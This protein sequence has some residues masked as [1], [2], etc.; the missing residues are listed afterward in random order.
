M[1]HI[2]ARLLDYEA[3]GIDSVLSVV[4]GTVFSFLVGSAC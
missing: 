3:G 2:E 4:L 1:I